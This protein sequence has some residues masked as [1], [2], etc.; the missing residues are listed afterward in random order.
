MLEKNQLD[1]ETRIQQLEGELDELT[2]ALAQAWDQLVPLLQPPHPTSDNPDIGLILDSILAATD[3]KI[4]ALYLK[5]NNQW[6]TYPPGISL[7][8]DLITWLPAHLSDGEAI[9]WKK[10]ARWVFVPFV[11]E[12]IMT[13]AIGCCLTD[14]EREFTAVEVRI[15]KRLTERFAH[16]IVAERLAQSRENEA[17][18]AHEMEIANAIQ[19]SILPARLPKNPKIDLAALWNP[20]QTVGG[21]AWG[22][23]T[24]P[25]GNIACFLLDVSGKGLPAALAAV[26]LHTAIIMGLRSGMPPAETMQTINAEFYDAYTETSLMA[27]VCIISFDLT[28]GTIEQANAGHPPTLIRNDGHWHQLNAT[29]P[30]VG[31]LPD[32]FPETQRFKLKSDVILICYSDGFIEIPTPS[33]LWGIDGLIS[34]IPPESSDVKQISAAIVRGVQNLNHPVELHDDQTLLVIRC[35]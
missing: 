11:T 28:T 10:E 20:A 4:A 18:L 35:G 9:A 24:Q 19:R 30:P 34:S 33:G 5:N 6:Y 12:G 2:E 25:N 8:L 23:V 3:T 31:V 17:R 7:P 26:S 13:G 15:L 27:T 21:D 22:W 14:V 29:V 1:Y 16:Q 32:I